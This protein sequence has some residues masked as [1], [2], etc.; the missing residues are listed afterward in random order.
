[1]L[2]ELG[3]RER[4]EAIEVPEDWLQ[5]FPAGGELGWSSFGI[6]G[7]GHQAVGGRLASYPPGA[8]VGDYWVDGDE[9]LVLTDRRAHAAVGVRAAGLRYSPMPAKEPGRSPAPLPRQDRG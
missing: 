7:A 4:A 5:L 2:N 3:L 8:R 6:T 9:G 1:M